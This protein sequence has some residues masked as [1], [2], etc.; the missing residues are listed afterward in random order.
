MNLEA[1]RSAYA[2]MLDERG[3]PGGDGCVD[4]EALLAVVDG[5]ATESE[6]LR[7]LG[8]VGACPRCR[9]ELDLLMTAADAAG[10]PAPSAPRFLTPLRAAAA[11]LLVAGAGVLWQ[12]TR[13][14]APDTLRL[15]E[16]DAV[17]LLAP[18]AGAAVAPP[19]TLTW[20]AV[21]SVRRYE[22]EVLDAAGVVAFSV[23]TADT[24]AAVPVGILAPGATYRW[25]VRATG[26]D[27]VRPS[28]LQP[29]RVTSP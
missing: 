21:P 24:S 29:L 7:T 1:L 11:I 5:S 8:H 23:A 28:P 9:A 10:S 16:G 15:G 13:P 22:V 18:N 26:L 3:A 2:R 17:R 27:G 14:P 20:A 4:P 6:R 25:W 19:V 12:A